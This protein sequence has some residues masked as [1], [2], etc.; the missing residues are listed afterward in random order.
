MVASP[1]VLI[2]F[3]TEEDRENYRHMLYSRVRCTTRYALAYA[4]KNAFFVHALLMHI[5]RLD[6]APLDAY[7]LMHS[8]CICIGDASVHALLM[9]KSR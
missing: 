9:H 5:G 1:R 8:L 4:Y 2:T 3:S 6:N 7:A